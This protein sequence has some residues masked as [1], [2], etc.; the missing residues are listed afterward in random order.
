M[1]KMTLQSCKVCMSLIQL[2]RA[3]M[4]DMY[5]TCTCSVSSPNLTSQNLL[6]AHDLEARAR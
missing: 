5:S 6:V 2:W 1:V 3:G 4:K